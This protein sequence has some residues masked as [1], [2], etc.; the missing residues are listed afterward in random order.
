VLVLC[1][2]DDVLEADEDFIGLYS[3][4]SISADNLTNAI[5]DCLKHLILPISKVCSQCYDGAS[6]MTGTKKGVA[7]QI[8]DV[9]K[10]VTFIHCYG[11]FVS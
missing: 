1:W 10:R 6:N 2:V 7:K 3:V 11:Q 8:Q 5:N 9:E 4:S